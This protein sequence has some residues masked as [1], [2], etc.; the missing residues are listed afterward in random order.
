M[1]GEFNVNP[2][3]SVYKL[4]ERVQHD[5]AL[6]NHR[7]TMTII[8]NEI[9][10]ATLKDN[11]QTTIFSAFQR[12]SRFIPQIERYKKLAQKAKAIYVFGV[13][14]TTLPEIDGIVYVPL[15][16]TDQLTKEWFLVSYGTDFVSALATQELTHIDDPDDQRVFKGIW[17]F[18]IELAAILHEWLS[19]TVGLR[20]E[21]VTEVFNREKQMQLM[22]NIIVRMTQR[23]DKI[24]TSQR[25]AVLH[26]ELNVALKSPTRR[27]KN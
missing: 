8:S 4:V 15:K 27:I 7:R 10:N 17:T 21:L 19:T 6:V 25:D 9:E 23:I 22:G 24:K 1:S 18:E 5:V 3:F 16:P 2:I 13:P 26:A 20:P 14:D 12:Y 11:A